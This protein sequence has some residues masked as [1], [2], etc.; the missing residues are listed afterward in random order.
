MPHSLWQQ[1]CLLTRQSPPAPRGS[2]PSQSPASGSAPPC[3]NGHVAA[4][5]SEL[6][7]LRAAARVVAHRDAQRNHW[8]R[9]AAMLGGGAWCGAAAVGA[10]VETVCNL[11]TA[12]NWIPGSASPSL[13]GVVQ[14]LQQ[15]GV[16]VEHR[17]RLA[18]HHAAGRAHHLAAKHLHAA[19]PA[20][21][22]W[23][24]NT[25]AHTA[26]PAMARAPP[27]RCT[28][29]PCTVVPSW[30]PTAIPA[31][32]MHRWPMHRGSQLATNS[33][34]HLA[35]A[36][37]AHAHAKHGEAAGAQLLDDLQADAAV[38]GPPCG[39]GWCGV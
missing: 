19:V 7:S 29:G 1:V 3:N 38:L 8:Q 36:L 28:A 20:R 12:C 27:G 14:P 39:G 22:S 2:C 34:S 13:E 24:N 26:Q 18:V 35:D 10:M 21:I 32:L 37:V 33:S 4:N 17:T 9:L 5:L 23:V 16:G 30:P 25:A 15:P 31:W 11:K 6:G